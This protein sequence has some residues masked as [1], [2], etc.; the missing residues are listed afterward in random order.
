MKKNDYQTPEMEVVKL[1]KKSTLLLASCST[2]CDTDGT[3][4]GEGF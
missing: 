4:G 3:S 2:Q 1:N